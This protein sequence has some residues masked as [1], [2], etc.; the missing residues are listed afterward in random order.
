MEQDSNR[1]PESQEQ[2]DVSEAQ[3]HFALNR[4]RDNQNLPAA[5]LA[6]AAAALVGAGIW[7]FIVVLTEYQTGLVAIG[8]G[9]LVAYA[10]RFAGKGID[11]IFGVVGAIFA[12]LGCLLGNLLTASYLIAKTEGIPFLDVLAQVDFSLVVEIMVATF[13]PMDILFYAIAVYFGYR[14]AFRPVTA[15]DLG[16]S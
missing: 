12:L 6:G 15:E 13:E 14:Y 10:V 11:R 1:G 3:K 5:I 8:V 9:F 7:A 2:P 16:R 4:L